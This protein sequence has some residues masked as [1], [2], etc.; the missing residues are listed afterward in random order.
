MDFQTL[1]LFDNDSVKLAI[2]RIQTAE[3]AKTGYTVEN[4][5][6]EYEEARV[7]ASKTNQPAAM[8]SA[9]TGKA[10]LYGYDKDAGTAEKVV[11][12]VSPA[13]PEDRLSRAIEGKTVD[14]KEESEVLDNE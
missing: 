9:I 4:A 10:R 12:M 8:V 6:D 1:K 11:I 2:T 3:V 7:L 13:V 14:T 5:K